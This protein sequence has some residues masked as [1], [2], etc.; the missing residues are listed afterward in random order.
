MSAAYHNNEPRS[1]LDARSTHHETDIISYF[2]LVTVGD[3]ITNELGD[4]LITNILSKIREYTSGVK[5]EM[6][7][8]V[9]GSAS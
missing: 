3:K 9:N 5:G 7:C 8:D 2:A 1:L 4:S 6:A